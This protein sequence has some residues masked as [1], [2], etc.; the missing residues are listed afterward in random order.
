MKPLISIITVVYNAS[1]TIEDSIK[2]VIGQKTKNYQYIIIDG[3]S[4]DGTVDI[5]KKY[6]NNIDVFLTEK[7]KGI[8]D[9]MNKGLDASE[10]EYVY[11]LGA[12]DFL[13]SDSLTTDLLTFIQDK[14]PDLILGNIKYTHGQVITPVFNHKLLLHNSVHHQGTF[15]LSKHFNSFRYD[16]SFKLISDYELNLNLY[17]ARKSLKLL[18]I[19]YIIALCTDNGMSRSHIDLSLHETNKIRRKCLNIIPSIFLS[20]IY[21]VKL[22]IWNVRYNKL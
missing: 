9:A 22:K 11:F 2:S 19:D 5:I 6:S 16:I 15:Y 4:N 13:H 3:A 10:G 18:F 1:L 12:D 20:L 14:R 8:Y 7:D 17:L 21:A